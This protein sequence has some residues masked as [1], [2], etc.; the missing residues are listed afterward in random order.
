MRSKLELL[1]HLVEA[2]IH[3]SLQFSAA[4]NGLLLCCMYLAPLKERL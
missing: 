1:F 2:Y 3:H 4:R